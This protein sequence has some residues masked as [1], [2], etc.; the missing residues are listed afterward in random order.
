[1]SNREGKP[2]C[3]FNKKSGYKRAETSPFRT[4]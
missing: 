4:R 3:I 2:A 1:M